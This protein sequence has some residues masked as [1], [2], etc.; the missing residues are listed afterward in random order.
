MAI[1]VQPGERPGKLPV[2]TNELDNGQHLPVY[3][4]AD[5]SGVPIDE[6]NPLPVETNSVELTE[7]TFMQQEDIL[8]VIRSLEVQLKIMNIHLQSMTG[9]EITKEDL[10]V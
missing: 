7:R 8:E 2:V 3:T 1:D 10:N 5:A 4:A 9:E 6:N